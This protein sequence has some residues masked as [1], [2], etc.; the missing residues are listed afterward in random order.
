MLKSPHL[1]GIKDLDEESIH[2]IVKTAKEFKE[3][4]KAIYMSGYNTTTKIY[5][6]PYKYI[7]IDTYD[8]ALIITVMRISHFLFS[9]DH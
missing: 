3:V 7:I 2:L 9:C 1:L 4:C 6:P 5:T 8:G